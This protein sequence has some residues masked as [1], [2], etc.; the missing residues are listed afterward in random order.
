MDAFFVEARERRCGSD[1]VEA[2][3]VIE[4]TKVH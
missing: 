4:K 1:T 2:V 3:T